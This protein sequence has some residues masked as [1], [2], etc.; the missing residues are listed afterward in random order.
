MK[1]RYSDGIEWEAY[2][3]L[4]KARPELFAESAQIPIVTD[5]DRVDK[6]VN[7]TGEKVGVLYR[8]A[9]H[10]LVVDLV[11][12]LDGT[13]YT[14]ERLIPAVQTGTVAA[15]TVQDGKFVLLKQYRH[16]IRESQY[17]FPRGFGENGIL[18]E[19]N[20]KKEI[21]EEMKAM[22]TECVYLGEVIADSGIL[23]TK[24]SVFACQVE[25][26]QKRESYEGIEEVVFLSP[27]EL[28]KWIADGKITDGFT[29][30]A[31]SLYVSEKISKNINK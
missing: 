16:A 18:P 13:L 1:E 28:Q 10:Y 15:V 11:R 26:V 14:Y 6:F 17:C 29:L 7:E 24:V 23:G 4:Q 30:S 22:V 21:W 2:E 5:R 8:S 3:E 19:E 27:E 20:V 12:N 9:Y 31:Y 25:Q